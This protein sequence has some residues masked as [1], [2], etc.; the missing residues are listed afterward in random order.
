MENGQ[1]LVKKLAS[2]FSVG[3]GLEIMPVPKS[4]ESRESRKRKSDPRKVVSLIVAHI[5]VK[6]VFGFIRA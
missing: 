3:V 4:P 1:K 5:V 6:V 2:F